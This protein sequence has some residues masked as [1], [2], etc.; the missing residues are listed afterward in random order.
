MISPGDGRGAR[1]RRGV[2]GQLEEERFE[3]GDF[4]LQPVH[5]HAVPAELHDVGVEAF[6]DR[7]HD[8]AAL[9]VRRGL[10]PRGAPGGLDRGRIVTGPQPPH[11]LGRPL[12]HDGE[13]SGEHDPAVIQD[14]HAVADLLHLGHVVTAQQHGQAVAGQAAQR[15]PQIPDSGRVHAVGGLVQDQ[16]PGPAEHG[17]GQA[18]PLA[19]P[20]GVPAHL[21]ASGP[22][23]A[24][25]LDRLVDEGG[26]VP[27]VKPA[28]MTRFCRPVR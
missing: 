28:R 24:C 12:P 15:G 27:A 1:W 16:Q 3:R 10:D 9:V 8:Q 14:R 23:Q 11:G 4:E 26:R 6:L 20:E 17:R 19:H 2:P 18:Q 7:V 5:G 13:A 25:R 22:G 21:L